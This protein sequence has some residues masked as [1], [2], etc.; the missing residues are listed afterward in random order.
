MQG[1]KAERQEREKEIKKKSLALVKTENVSS[2]RFIFFPVSLR[3]FL[4]KQQ[5]HRLGV[6]VLYKCEKCNLFATL[7]KRMSFNLQ[8][9]LEFRHW[10]L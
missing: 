9:P 6:Y 2:T 8:S 5:P 4:N 3:C 10:L 1:L 7:L